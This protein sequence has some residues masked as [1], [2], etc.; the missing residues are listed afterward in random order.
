[1]LGSTSPILLQR[2]AFF[3]VSGTQRP[4]AIST[5]CLRDLDRVVKSGRRVS[6]K[7]VPSDPTVFAFSPGSCSSWLA[8]RR[9]LPPTG[10]HVLRRSPVITFSERFPWRPSR[11]KTTGQILA[12][13]RLELEVSKFCVEFTTRTQRSHGKPILGQKASRES[14]CTGCRLHLHHRSQRGVRHSAWF[15]GHPGGT[16]YSSWWAT[17]LPGCHHP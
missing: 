17:V 12:V 15:F 16:P 7:V 2:D 4:F 13:D 11:L 3:R 8:S 6:W 5:S 14:R 10:F 9:Q 1:M